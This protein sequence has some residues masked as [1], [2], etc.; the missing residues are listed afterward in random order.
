MK[1]T[2]TPPRNKL[3]EKQWE[4]ALPESRLQPVDAPGRPPA[5]M[6]YLTGWNWLRLKALLGLAYKT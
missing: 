3:Y 5:Q 4:F 2:L 6:Q 1:S